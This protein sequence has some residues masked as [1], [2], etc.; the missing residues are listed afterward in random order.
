MKRTIKTN[1]RPYDRGWA[2]IS[3]FESIALSS[4]GA[5]RMLGAIRE[6]LFKYGFSVA[7]NV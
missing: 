2:P 3:N 4:N 7:D 5:I 6:H 1:W